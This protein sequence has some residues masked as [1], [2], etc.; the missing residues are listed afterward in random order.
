MQLSQL[1]RAPNTLVRRSSCQANIVHAESATMRVMDICVLSIERNIGRPGWSGMGLV[2]TAL[3]D[4]CFNSREVRRGSFLI[5][6]GATRALAL[7]GILCG[8]CPRV[9]RGAEAFAL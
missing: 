6:S 4:T 9:F 3:S 5:E 1:E 7:T 8:D 2:S